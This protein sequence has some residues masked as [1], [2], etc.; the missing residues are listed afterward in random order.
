[1]STSTSELTEVEAELCVNMDS[2]I[3]AERV[4][5]AVLPEIETWPRGA[6]HV[7]IVVEG[8]RVCAYIHAAGISDVRAALNS[9]GSWLH[10]AAT[11]LGECV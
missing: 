7:K 6:T 9:V 3:E 1:M 2:P 11:L 8:S 4:Y 10:L 5:R